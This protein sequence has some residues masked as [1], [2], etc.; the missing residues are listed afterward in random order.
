[1][2]MHIITDFTASAGTETMLARLLRSSQDSRIVVAPL[3]GV[4]ERNR[5]L[6]A[7][8]NVVYK[9]QGAKS[10]LVLC[11]RVISLARLIQAEQPTIILCWMYHAMATGVVALELAGVRAKLFWNIRQSLD[12]VNAL[13][14][15]SRAAIF[16]CKLLSRVPTGIIYNSSRA[17]ALHKSYGYRNLNSVVIPNGYDL[18]PDISI[19]PKKPHVFGIAGRFHPQKDYETFFRAAALASQSNPDV[20]FIAAGHGLSWDNINVTQLIDDAGLSRNCIELRGEVDDMTSFYSDIDALVLSSRTEGF[21]NVV[22]EAMEQGRP[23]ISTDVGDAALVVGDTGFVVPS[24]QA[25]KLATAMLRLLALAP[26]TYAGYARAARAR[27]NSEYS[28]GAIVERYERF[29]NA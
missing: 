27:I 23:V 3:I 6:A 16:A 2:I 26:E 5:N 8:P 4:S 7:N 20:R 28:L 10:G 13:T 9:P 24:R 19:T 14:R 11:R 29:L 12:D 17:L 18:H 15:S 21:P 25:D 1:M 22:A